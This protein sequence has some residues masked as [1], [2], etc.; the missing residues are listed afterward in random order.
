MTEKTDKPTEKAA[1][2]SAVENFKLASNYLL[3]PIPEEL[4]DENSFFGK[5]SI[6]LLKHH[7]TYQQDNRDQRG[8]EGQGLQLYGSLSDT[9]WQTDPVR[10]CW[11][12]W[13]SATKWV[14]ARCASQRGKGCSCMGW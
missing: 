9:W 2:P 14:T 13:I 1:K 4:A 12:S 5:A 11:P 6:Q 10:S 8:K 7:G 3:G